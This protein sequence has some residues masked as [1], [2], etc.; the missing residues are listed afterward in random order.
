[1]KGT[2]EQASIAINQLQ[3]D[4]DNPRL[5]VDMLGSDQDELAKHYYDNA[6]IDKLIESMLENGFFPHEPLIV[7]KTSNSQ[8]KVVEGNRRLTALYLIHN[9]VNIENISLDVENGTKLSLEEVPCI[10]SANEDDIRKYIGYR[11]ISGLREWEPAEKARFVAKE[12][13]SAKA[14]GVSNPFASVAKAVGSSAQKIR[15]YYAALKLLEFAE[16]E[17]Q[18]DVAQVRSSRFGVWERLMSGPSYKSFISYS[19][20]SN[21]YDSVVDAV[22]KINSKHLEESIRDL[23]ESPGSIAVLNDSRDATNYG[24]V[25]CN[26]SARKVLRETG[27]LK[28]AISLIEESNFA[29]KVIRVRNRV[30]SLKKEIE[31]LEYTHEIEDAVKQLNSSIKNLVL[32]SKDIDEE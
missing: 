26:E 9:K 27:D 2:L 31:S 6:V 28:A 11:H 17:Y 30:E 29:E 12:V 18:I 19:P 16:N 10:I 15:E 21:D 7:T 23:K 14:K 25:L 8:Y 22:K 20:E 13:D 24:R 1:M 32:L 5:P 3:Y 4:P